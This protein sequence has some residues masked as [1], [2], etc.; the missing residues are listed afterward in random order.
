MFG[1]APLHYTSHLR[2]WTNSGSGTKCGGRSRPLSAKDGSIFLG[3]WGTDVPA[4]LKKEVEDLEKR[5][6][7]GTLTV[8]L[9]SEVMI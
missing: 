7:K 5:F 9:V 1:F 3:T 4:S 8:E 6:Q 2:L